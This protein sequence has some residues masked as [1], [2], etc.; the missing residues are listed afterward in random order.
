MT[1]PTIDPPSAAE[2]LL[3]VADFLAE[4]LAPVQTDGK[5]RYRTLIAA[6]LLRIA[7]RELDVIDE[8]QVD[9]DGRAAPAE[10]IARA[11]SVRE[12]AEALGAGHSSLTD[13]NTF[14]LASGYVEAKLKIAIPETPAVRS[15]GD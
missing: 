2:L 11:G 5:L 15:S 10:L 13:A 14:A 1:Q 4:E 12:L 8:L 3:L 9:A 6:N 7:R